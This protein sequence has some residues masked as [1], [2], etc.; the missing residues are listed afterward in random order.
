MMLPEKESEPMSVANSIG[1]VMAA[2]VSC[3]NVMPAFS[4]GFAPLM[5]SRLATSAAA[6]PPRPLK[7][8]TICGIAVIFTEYAPSAPMTRP[9]TIPMMMSR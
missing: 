7:S 8:A 9:M 4:V 1:I 5:N 2:E 3:G 6:P